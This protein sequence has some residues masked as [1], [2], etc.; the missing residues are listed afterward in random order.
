LSRLPIPDGDDGT[1]GDILNDFLLQ[2]HNTDGTQK[3]LPV[4]RGGTDATDASTAR[5]NLGTIS[6]SDSRLSDARIPTAHKDSHKTSGSDALAAADIDAV[7]TSRTVAGKALTGD[8]T[9]SEIVLDCLLSSDHTATGVKTTLVAAQAQA[10]GD[11]CYIGSDG[12]AHLALADAIANANAIAMVADAT[13]TGDVTGNYLLYGTVRDD[14]W[15]WTVGGFIYLSTTGT[16]G[17]TLTQTAPSGTNNVIQ[18]LGVATSADEIIFS[19][20]LV[21]VEHV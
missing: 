18:I 7:P 13:I 14:S 3:T 4:T 19:P 10:I 16:T 20:Q 2:E 8:V 1:W 17:N 21:Q 5:T 15:S 11:A 12:K 6:S 9:I